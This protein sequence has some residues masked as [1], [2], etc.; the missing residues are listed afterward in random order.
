M[1]SFSFPKNMGESFFNNF[2]FF[3]IEVWV[4]CKEARERNMEEKQEG[5][6]QMIES[7]MY[8][9]LNLRF[10]FSFISNIQKLYFFL[11]VIFGCFLVFN[12]WTF[13]VLY[14]LCF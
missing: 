12:V 13:L 7:S 3:L 4:F 2:F 6:K 1:D 10:F 9:E 5:N 8:I 14:P 11:L